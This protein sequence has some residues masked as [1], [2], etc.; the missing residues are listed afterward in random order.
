MGKIRIA[1]AGLGSRGE[2]CYGQALLE[3]KDRAEVVALAEPRAD[4]LKAAAEAH[5][6]PADRCFATVEEMLEQPKLADALVLCTQD[7]QHV[8]QAI[9]ALKKG[10]HIMMEK[11]ISPELEDLRRIVQ[12][13][14]ECQRRVLVCHVLRYT[15]FFGKIKDVI[16]SGVIG[17]VVAIQTI[18]NV[19]YW[20]QAH[21]FVRGNWRNS[22]ETSPMIMQKCCH[23]LDYL[24]W[25]SGQRCERV[26]SFGSLKHFRPECAPEGAAMRCLDGCKAKE[27]CPFDAEKIYLTNEKTGVLKGNKGWP[28]DVLALDPTEESVRAAIETGPYGRCVYHCDN[29]VVD[30][31]IVNME[32]ENGATLTLT[33]CAFTTAGSRT[34]TIMGTKGDIRA[35]MSANTIRVCAFG[36]QPEVIDVTKLAA[37]FSGHGG[38]DKQLISQFIDIVG[39]KEPDSRVTTLEA[40]VESHLVALAAEESRKNSG[41]VIE[42]A[43]MRG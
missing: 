6:V 38:G 29:N 36:G 33:M 23:D 9:V 39:G 16:D 15:P 40:S 2:S 11:P 41:K 24:V 28:L 37:D 42:I 31:Q 1:I 10:Y 7:R 25:L 14:R 17:E 27:Y 18:E 26:S 30:H 21:S 34:L 3:M 43:P 5:G 8:P 12:V 20:H 35:D 32:M 4:R 22:G 13:A 19:G